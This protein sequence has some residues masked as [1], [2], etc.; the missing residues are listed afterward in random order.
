M[1][2]PKGDPA[3]L[4]RAVDCVCSYLARRDLND[5]SAAELLLLTGKPCADALLSYGC[6][7]TEVPELA[8]R[9]FQQKLCNVLLFSGGI[10]H[11]TQG[12]RKNAHAKYGMDCE[13]STEAE[14]MAEIAIRHL[15]V[16]KEKVYIEKFSTNSGENAK[17][18]IDLLAKNAVPLKSIVLLQDPLMQQR[19]H[20]ATLKFLDPG[21]MLFS[22]AP[23]IP[24]ADETRP[25]P[26]ER[27]YE[28]ILREIPR[29][30]DDEHG[31]GPN[32]LNYIVHADIPPEVM[33][34]YIYIKRSFN[35]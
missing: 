10:G 22:Y 31:Y 14:I 28:L 9:I 29:I 17:F 18:S 7:L 4:N 21:C 30:Y 15:H 3:E 35:Q 26:D 24:R 27:F 23:F 11:G 32:G 20:L 12:L 5:L 19:S 25:W 1:I 8:A 13:D 6:D 16:P 33:Q 2:L 34:S